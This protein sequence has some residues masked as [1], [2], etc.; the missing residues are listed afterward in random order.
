MSRC[1]LRVVR[2]GQPTTMPSNFA[3]VDRSRRCAP[4]AP[5]YSGGLA[6]DNLASTDS[7]CLAASSVPFRGMKSAGTGN[8]IAAVL[9]R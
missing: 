6:S 1:S 2:A 5:D 4:A 9:L 8:G 7:R 3:I